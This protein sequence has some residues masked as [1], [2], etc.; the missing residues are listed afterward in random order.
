MASGVASSV[1]ILTGDTN[2]VVP[3][4]A[5]VDGSD[6]TERLEEF[7]ADCEASDEAVVFTDVLG[8]SV[9]QKVSVA[10]ARHPGVM[11]VT[12]MSLGLVIEALLSPEPL[13]ADVLRGIV[14]TARSTMQ[15]VEVPAAPPA[16]DDAT[17]DEGSFFS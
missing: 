10:L 7:L 8:G 4:D 14:E 17:E 6:W 12:G 9:F 1:A 11:H 5:Y 3:I 13:T 16:S 15:V 2:S